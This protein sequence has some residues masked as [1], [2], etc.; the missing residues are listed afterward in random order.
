MEV[1]NLISRQRQRYE[2]LAIR[3]LTQHRRILR[4]D[5]DGILPFLRESC[6]IDHKECIVC[7]EHLIHLTR[8]FQT[9]RFVVPDAIGNEMMETIV[10]SRSQA[11][12]HR[13][14]ALTISGTDQTGDIKRTH[15][16]AGHTRSAPLYGQR[17]RPTG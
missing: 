4:G 6:V 12:G 15:C 2:R 9:E 3:S 16:A 11:C 1:G 17:A 13:L 14:N 7:A 5:A 8:Q 10:L